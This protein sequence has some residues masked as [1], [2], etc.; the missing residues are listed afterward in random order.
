MSGDETMVMLVSMVAGAI[1]WYW[2]YAATRVKTLAIRNTG[3]SLFVV[4]PP[5]CLVLL[6]VVLR[7]WAADDVRYSGTYLAFYTFAGAAWV[8]FCALW[9]GFLG[10]SPR[11]DAIERQNLA[12]ALA[13]SGAVVGIT[14]SFAGANIGNGP[15]WWVVVFS[16]G[17]ATIAF[18]GLWAM[19]ERLTTISESVTVDR[20]VGAGL[21]LGGLLIAMGMI[22]GRAVAGDWVSAAATVRDF[23][24]VAWPVVPLTLLAVVVERVRSP[25]ASHHEGESL[26]GLFVAMVYLAIA[27]LYVFVW[28]GHP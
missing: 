27:G 22:L 21:R 17:L 2:W 4:T 14:F 23:A 1:A 18:F 16:A 11:D 28:Q 12:A 15:G 13:I 6:F 20:L 3:R 19:I 8:G 25:D 24:L 7:L 26:V 10:I 5:I 9:L